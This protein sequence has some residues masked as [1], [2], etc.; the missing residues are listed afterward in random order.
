MV[1]GADSALDFGVFELGLLFRFVAF[2]FVACFPCGDGSEEYVFCDRY[3]VGLGA[4][5][6]ALFLSEFGP[7]FSLGDARVHGGFHHGLLD[8]AGCLVA[9]AIVAY[10]V[11]YNRLGSVF[12]LGDGLGWELERVVVF[13]R[14]IG[15]AVGYISDCRN[16][17]LLVPRAC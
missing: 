2:V 14:P 13:F 6:L 8:A 5:G 12:V 7:L 11:R 9:A 10:A 4:C 1:T 16:L 15:A 17:R 3:G